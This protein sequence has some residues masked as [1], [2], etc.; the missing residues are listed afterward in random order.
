MKRVDPNTVH[1]ERV[2]RVDPKTVRPERSEGSDHASN[3]SAKPQRERMFMKLRSNSKRA[4]VVDA[5]P[6]TPT[7]D[8][9]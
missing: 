9:S 1:S 3:A 7:G 8:K 5:K 2:K 6:P 4:K